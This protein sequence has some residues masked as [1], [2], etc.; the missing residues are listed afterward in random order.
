MDL[1]EPKKGNI[2]N[3]FS[4]VRKIIAIS[5]TLVFCYLSVIGTITQEQFIPVFSMVLGYY[6]GKST[7]L[8]IPATKR[9]DGEDKKF[10]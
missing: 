9:T 1:K 6:F 10:E 3:I 5:L 2:F 7:A 4:S 8:D